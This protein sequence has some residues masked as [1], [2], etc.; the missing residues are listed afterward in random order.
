MLWRQ[1]WKPETILLLTTIPARAIKPNIDITTPNGLSVISNNKN[2]PPVDSM[3]ADIVTIVCQ[4]EL[5]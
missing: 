3:I 2:I 1:W 4:A 5:N